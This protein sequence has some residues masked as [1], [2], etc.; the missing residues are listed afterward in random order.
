MGLPP[1]KSERDDARANQDRAGQHQVM[2]FAKPKRKADN[3]HEQEH[4]GQK[5]YDVFRS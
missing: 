2:V 5:E 4:P 3:S 1:A